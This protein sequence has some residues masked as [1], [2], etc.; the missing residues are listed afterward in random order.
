MLKAVLWDMGGPIDK[1]VGY[2]RLIDEDM[3]RVLTEAG[4]AWSEAD[5][6]EAA[7]W[8]VCLPTRFRSSPTRAP[9]RCAGSPLPSFS[10][11]R[12]ST[13]GP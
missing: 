13:T 3:K 5:F 8:A 11:L 4:I 9:T 1:E 2:E 6:R 7:R 10:E 12:A